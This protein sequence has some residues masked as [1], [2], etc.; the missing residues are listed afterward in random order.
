ME[1]VA[2]LLAEMIGRENVELNPVISAGPAD[3]EKYENIIF[4]ISTVGRETW[5]AEGP[6]S[7]WDIFMPML[8]KVNWEGK[9]VALYGLGDHIAYAEYFVDA[10]GTL[11]EELLKNG[12]HIVGHVSPEEYNF[13]QSKGVIDGKF[14]GLPLDEDYEADKTTGRLER[15]LKEIIP[16]FHS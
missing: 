8:E 16:A 14:I 5:E 10:L 4:G 9:V 1:R 13:I 12:A 15:W 3:I 2:H 7:D 11:G 6:D